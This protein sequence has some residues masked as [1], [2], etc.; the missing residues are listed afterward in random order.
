MKGRE[1]RGREGTGRGRE[2]KRKENRL[3]GKRSRV[4]YGNRT[5]AKEVRGN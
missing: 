5:G 1:G 4:S 2:E 3:G